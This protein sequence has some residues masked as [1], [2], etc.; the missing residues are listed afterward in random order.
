MRQFHAADQLKPTEV[1]G[2]FDLGERK[3]NQHFRLK[4]RLF[5]WSEPTNR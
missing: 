1:L 5:E 3:S 2:G 4:R